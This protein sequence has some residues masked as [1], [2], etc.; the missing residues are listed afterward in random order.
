MNGSLLGTA[1][2]MFYIIDAVGVLPLA[3]F[4]K[5]VRAPIREQNNRF[6]F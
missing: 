3:S 4:L 6:P 2:S 5:A 1:Y